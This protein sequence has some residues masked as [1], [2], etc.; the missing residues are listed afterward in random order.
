MRMEIETPSERQLLFLKETHR[1]VGYGGARGG[2]KSWAIRTKAK[3]LALRW[4]GIKIMIVRQTYPELEANH[5]KELR[6]ELKCDNPDKKQRI[7]SYNDA[8]KEMH[9]FN[10]SEILFRYCSCERDLGRFQGTQVDVLFVD[11]STQMEWSWIIEIDACVRGV[12]D[13][14]KRTYLTCNPGGRSHSEHK[15]IFIDKRFH[16]REDGSKWVFIPA[17]VTDNHALM[18]ADPDYIRT[19]EALPEHKR[20]MWLEGEW[21]VFEGQFFEDLRLSPDEKLCAAAGITEEEARQQ[22]RFVHVIEPFK[23]PRGWNIFRSYDYGYNKPFSCAWW[24]VDYDGVMY[25]ILELYGWDGEPDHGCRWTPETQFAKIAELERTHPM[26]AGRR[27]NDGV[28]DPAIWDASRG[29]S[30]AETAARYGIYFDKGD[31]KRLPGWMQCHN[32]L[33]FDENGYPRCYIFSTC[34]AFI[35]T[36]PSLLFCKTNPEDLDTT[37]ED[38]VADEWRYACM[39]R[40][41]APIL[42]KTD[43]QVVLDPLNHIKK[44]DERY[45]PY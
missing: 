7:A 19:L 38:H 22:R 29:E 17:R 3:L 12:N 37:M 11:E 28:A 43:R 27:I 21:D 41:V 1:Y 31:N 25:R 18:K 30:I 15:R 9:F 45:M 24:A 14:P 26:L 39:S 44:N 42:P 6:K 5:I 16:E 20:K 8:K 13:F 34:A 35:R 36:I 32:R 2:G 40:P 23:I 10:G 33:Q 4:P